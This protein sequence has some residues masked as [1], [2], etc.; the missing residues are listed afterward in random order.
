MR[1]RA[2]DTGSGV[3]S[4]E[5]KQRQTRMP[6]GIIFSFADNRAVVKP[7]LLLPDGTH[8]VRVHRDGEQGS[9][10]DGTRQKHRL[11]LTCRVRTIDVVHEAKERPRSR[12]G[13]RDRRLINDGIRNGI[14]SRLRALIKTHPAAAE[15]MTIGITTSTGPGTCIGAVPS[16]DPNSLM[17]A[18]TK[19][20]LKRRADG[21]QKDR[22]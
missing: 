4:A 12:E 19:L 1:L 18:P 2:A 9:D 10:A 22:I 8:L 20:R 7:S 16:P 5:E 21:K 3:S 6:T 15:Q 11:Q 13:E 14:P 17:N